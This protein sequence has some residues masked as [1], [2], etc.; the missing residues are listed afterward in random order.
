MAA[1]RSVGKGEGRG[2][3][4]EKPAR[5]RPAVRAAEHGARA[6]KVTHALQLGA[7]Q[8]RRLL[9]GQRNKLVASTSVVWSR[10]IFEPA[11]AHHWLRD[12]GAMAQG[13]G[14]VVDDAVR[15]GIAGMRENLEF[16]ALP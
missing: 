12:A 2:L 8:I 9:P 14:K 4:A 16:T 1:H 3:R 15:I 13:A 6:M 11:T 10:S 7:E 5:A